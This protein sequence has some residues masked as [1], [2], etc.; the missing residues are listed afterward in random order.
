MLTQQ[1]GKNIT[2]STDVEKAFDKMKHFFMTKAN[3]KLGIE[4][5]SST[6]KGYL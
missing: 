3:G 4:G 1:R 6:Y 2:T 5:N